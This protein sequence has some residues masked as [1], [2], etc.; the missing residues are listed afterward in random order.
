MAQLEA[1][2]QAAA[3]AA[4][5]AGLSAEEM[6]AYESLDLQP[7]VEE[8]VIIE[9]NCLCTTPERVGRADLQNRAVPDQDTWV[10]PRSVARTVPEFP[11]QNHEIV[12]LRGNL[13]YSN[14]RRPEE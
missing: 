8:V 11:P 10:R 2:E 12:S 5:G 1:E 6:L 3:A 7:I 4:P 14:R 13:G 9:E